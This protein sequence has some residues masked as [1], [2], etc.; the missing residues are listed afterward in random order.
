MV[1]LISA[2]R[3]LRSGVPK[4]EG[5]WPL[6]CGWHTPGPPQSIPDPG[7]RR[8]DLSGS[9]I[10]QIWWGAGLFTSALLHPRTTV[11]SRY[12][13]QPIRLN[14]KKKV[15]HTD[16][17]G[18]LATHILLKTI[19]LYTITRTHCTASELFTLERNI[20]LA[21]LGWLLWPPVLALEKGSLTE[22]TAFPVGV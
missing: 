3:L 8:K 10:D 11:R 16:W 13:R 20:C 12:K 5:A 21:L 15:A 9:Q 7:Q 2:A 4:L 19:L 22:G 14:M 17:N 1:P 18:R 6:G